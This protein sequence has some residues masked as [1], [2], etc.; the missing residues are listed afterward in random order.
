MNDNITEIIESSSGMTPQCNG[1]WDKNEYRNFSSFEKTQ[2]ILNFC[3]ENALNCYDI[4]TEKHGDNVKEC[5][6]QCNL[7][8]NICA[9]ATSAAD[10]ISTCNGYEIKYCEGDNC[11]YN[12]L[13]NCCK[14]NCDNDEECEKHCLSIEPLLEKMDNI[15]YSK[16]IEKYIPEESQEGVNYNLVITLVVFLTVF[17]IVMLIIFRN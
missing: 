7:L 10:I 6:F 17:F 16:V 12:K 9:T 15:L 5:L 1:V 2:C 11:D 4:C 13:S 3:N 8:Y 14:Q